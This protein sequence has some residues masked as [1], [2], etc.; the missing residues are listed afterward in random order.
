MN[1]SLLS[2]LLLEQSMTV[3]EVF[4][5][6]KDG[7][8]MTHAGQVQAPD[9]TLALHYAKEGYGRR[10]ESLRLWVIPRTA[11]L[12]LT[13]PDFLQPALDKSYRTGAAYRIAVEK[14]QNIRERLGTLGTRKQTIEQLGLNSDEEVQP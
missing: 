2:D 1:E 6:E 10:G 12:E 13:D 3:Y 4:H 11:I 14:R 7:A 5:Q 9:E 8:P